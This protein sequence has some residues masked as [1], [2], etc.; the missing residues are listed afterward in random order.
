M[1]DLLPKINVI[2]AG[3]SVGSAEYLPCCFAARSVNI[4][5]IPH[6]LRSIVVANKQSDHLRVIIYF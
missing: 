5:H 1:W 3:M 4:H 2:V 6:P